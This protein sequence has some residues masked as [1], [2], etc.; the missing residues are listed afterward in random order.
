MRL[1]CSSQNVQTS[2]HSA[3]SKQE[4]RP[5]R[6]RSRSSLKQCQQS[7]T[8]NLLPTLRINDF[9]Y[10]SPRLTIRPKL[11]T[12]DSRFDPNAHTRK[13][14]CDGCE[15]SITFK[16]AGFGGA[17][18]YAFVPK[19]IFD[20]STKSEAITTLGKLYIKRY[21]NATWFCLTCWKAMYWQQDQLELSLDEVQSRL[22]AVNEKF[23]KVMNRCFKTFPSTKK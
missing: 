20:S 22:E 21:W 10:H 4:P 15:K 14:Y 16:G 3:S 23:D 5:H 6:C 17:G 7:E 13:I 19:S 11:R 2:Q 9:W 18:A 12:D 1:K 8:T